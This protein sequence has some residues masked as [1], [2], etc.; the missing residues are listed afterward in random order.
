MRLIPNGSGCE[1]LFTL[2][3]ME[4]MSEKQFQE[5]AETVLRDLRSLKAILESSRA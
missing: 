4:E 1:L 3:R 2:F 5:D